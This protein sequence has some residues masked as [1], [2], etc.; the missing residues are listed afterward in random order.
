M[1][2]EKKSVQIPG[3]VASLLPLVLALVTVVGAFYALKTDVVN[4]TRAVERQGS[5]LRELKYQ[6]E[7]HKE[8][9]THPAGAERFK[10]FEATL[11]E[12]KEGINELRRALLRGG[13]HER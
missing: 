1:G 3:W 12:V 5:E 11:S 8:L 13:R 4:N 2:D 6:L 10:A 9:P 7:E